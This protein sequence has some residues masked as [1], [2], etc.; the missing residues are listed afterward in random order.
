[1]TWVV[2]FIACWIWPKVESLKGPPPTVNQLVELNEIIYPD[3]NYDFPRLKQ[4]VQR[5]KSLR[6]KELE[7]QLETKKK[8]INKFYRKFTKQSWQGC[9]SSLL[10]ISRTNV[11]KTRKMMLMRK[12][13]LT[14][15]RMPYKII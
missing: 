12:T 5:L 15:L 6:S 13:Q 9:K 4:E 7:S 8:T 11:P 10:T 3:S 1:M 2:G 14:N